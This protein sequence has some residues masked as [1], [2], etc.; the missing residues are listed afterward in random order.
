MVYY[1]HVPKC[2]GSA[3]ARYLK[4]RFGPLGFYD[5]S[6]HKKRARNTAWSATSPQHVDVETLQSLIPLSFFKAMFAV[7]R[8]PVSRSLSAFHFQREVEGRIPADLAF[9]DWLQELETV[10]FARFDYDNHILPM[11][12]LVP[13]GASIFHL[14][15]GLDPLIVWLD[16]LTGNQAGPRVILPQN[17]RGALVAVQ[18]DK[19]TPTAKDIARISRIYAADFARF[20]YH[21]DQAMPDIPPPEISEGFLA[22]RDRALKA[23]RHPFHRLRQRLRRQLNRL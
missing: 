15:Y 14:E 5:V 17:A 8:H 3:I 7:V 9:S 13:E 22:E 6:F 1:A 12:L 10:G 16:Q 18:S 11:S 4:E 23:L 20:G 21:P 2:A 19:V